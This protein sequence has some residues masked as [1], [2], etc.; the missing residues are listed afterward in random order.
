MSLSG[1]PPTMADRPLCVQAIPA[2][3]APA[4]PRMA[5][6]RPSAAAVAAV[7]VRRVAPLAPVAVS[8]RRSGAVSL[9]IR[10]TDVA[11]MLSA[12]TMPSAVAPRVK[13]ARPG[14]RVGLDLHLVGVPELPY[15]VES[16]RR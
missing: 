9:R 7:I 4:M 15:G 8:V 6:S 13:S 10:P 12:I 14:L 3:T 2:M 16:A 11:S 5:P 1:T